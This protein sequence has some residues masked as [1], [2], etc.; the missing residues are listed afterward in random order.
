MIAKN[1]LINNIRINDIRFDNFDSKNKIFYEIF[2][3]TL[4]RD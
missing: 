4:F 3:S 2:F 1:T